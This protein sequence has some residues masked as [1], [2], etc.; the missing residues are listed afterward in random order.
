MLSVW[1]PHLGDIEAGPIRPT[2]DGVFSMK[3]FVLAAFAA[4][5]LGVA[6]VPAASAAA[7]RNSMHQG[8]YDNTGNGPQ[9]TGVEGGGG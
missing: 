3:K 8:A 1:T 9:E 2:L 7:L 5:S 6:L 4:L